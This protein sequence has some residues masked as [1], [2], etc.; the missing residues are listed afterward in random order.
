MT[1]ED[2]NGML[3]VWLTKFD[4]RVAGMDLVDAKSGKSK[5]ST[6]RLLSFGIFAPSRRL[7]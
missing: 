7:P 5:H 1:R 6:S 2:Y 4:A 3:E